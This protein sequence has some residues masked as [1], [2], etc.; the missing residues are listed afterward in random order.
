MVNFNGDLISDDKKFVSS[1]NRGFSYGDSLFET[2][3]FSGGKL[4]FWEDHYFRLMAS[5]RLLRM[6]IPM[7]FTPEFLEN[8]IKKTICIDQN[9]KDTFRVKL[10]VWR[11]DGGKYAPTTNEVDFCIHFEKLQIPFYTLIEEACEIELFKDHYIT[12]GILSTLKTN[13]KI[14]NVLGSIYAKE[15]GY[16]NCLLVNENKMIV[17]AL[18]SNIFLVN[19]YKIKTPPL[20]DG[21]LNGILR[22]QIIAIIAQMPDYVL[23]IES[24]TP[25]EL[26]K[27][28]EIFLTNVITGIRPV[29]KYRKKEFTNVVAKELLAKLNVRARLG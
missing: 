26:Q 1:F 24:V 4:F 27:A 21:C 12:S 22:L 17:E 19:G 20:E 2:M 5:M 13:N 9:M 15:N 3:R 6:E 11:K 8:E 23:E 14:I 28:D 10:Q 16:D 18:Q 25:F 29:S 7:S